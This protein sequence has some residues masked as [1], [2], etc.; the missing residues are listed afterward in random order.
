[1]GL[2]A[3]G[4]ETGVSALEVGVWGHSFEDGVRLWGLKFGA[5]GLYDDMYTVHVMVGEARNSR[6]HAVHLRLVEGQPGKAHT[7]DA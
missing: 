7:I 6:E 2:G 3:S 5:Y 4:S 1:M